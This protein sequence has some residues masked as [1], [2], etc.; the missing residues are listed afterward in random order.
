MKTI[1]LLT[2]AVFLSSCSLPSPME[3]A[4]KNGI[5]TQPDS[6]LLSLCY[7]YLAAVEQ[8][9]MQALNNMESRDKAYSFGMY[10][11][12]KMASEMSG[13]AKSQC[14]PGTN[15]WDATIA[16]YKADAETKK[17][18]IAEGG[19]T[20]RFLGGVGGGVMAI[21]KLAGKM[22]D[23]I[24]GTQT[25]GGRDVNTAGHG[26]ENSGVN[27]AVHHENV[28]T[29]ANKGD[30]TMSNTTSKTDQAAPAPAT[31]LPLE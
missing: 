18:L 10:Q 19:S 6:Q 17:A 7:N 22:G 1:L 11:M 26:I 9:E 2:L 5:S 16:W 31:E 8:Y 24:N 13:Y 21:D 28:Q 3:Q 15:V 14:Q 25:N 12:R 4:T 20:L 29:Q 27:T 23:T 30:S